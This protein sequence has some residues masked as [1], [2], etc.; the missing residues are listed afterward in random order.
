ME[1]AGNL[2]GKL[3]NLGGGIFG[4]LTGVDTS[5]G[6][7]PG[8]LNSP[9]IFGNNSVAG[10]SGA[11]LSPGGIP[12]QVLGDQYPSFLDFEIPGLYKPQD[13]M[14]P[15]EEKVDQFPYMDG[16]RPDNRPD[17]K[18]NFGLDGGPG[19]G[20]RYQEIGRLPDGQTVY[21]G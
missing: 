11:E 5:Q 2:L 8:I 13:E 1:F 12:K 16:N 20:G 19:I 17:N 6:I 7:V 21:I 4:G 14:R 10:M 15:E 9:N 3:G 18:E